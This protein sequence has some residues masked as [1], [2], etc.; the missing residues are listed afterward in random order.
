MHHMAEAARLA[1]VICGGSVF[2][3]CDARCSRIVRMRH[4]D[5]Q[6][7]AAEMET[8]PLWPMGARE[9]VSPHEIALIRWRVRRT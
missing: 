4:R 8:L 9:Y 1:G 5:Y 7:V 3:G 2:Q 6:W